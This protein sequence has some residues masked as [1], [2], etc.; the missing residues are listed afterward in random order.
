[1][2]PFLRRKAL[3]ASWPKWTTS[4]K[5]SMIYLHISLI[6]FLRLQFW[7]DTPH[8]FRFINQNHWSSVTYVDGN[9]VCARVQTKPATHSP[10]PV[11]KYIAQLFSFLL[12]LRLFHIWLYS[13]RAGTNIYL[14]FHHN[15]WCVNFDFFVFWFDLMKHY[16][17]VLKKTK[18]KYECV[19]AWL[20][21]W[22]C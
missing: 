13:R 4:K 17:F 19:F 18:S 16:K 14:L 6:S 21:K 1:M 8:S 15:F 2:R 20:M 3:R 5:R 7:D 11:G 22:S 12:R 9:R 10:T